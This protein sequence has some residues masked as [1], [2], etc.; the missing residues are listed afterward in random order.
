MNPDAGHWTFKAVDETETALLA[1]VIA[2]TLGPGDLV[3]LTGGLGAG[4][5]AFA[6]A[7]LRAL[8]GDPLLEVPSPT[9]TLMQTYDL[10]VGTAIHADFYRISG[11][12][13]LE[14]I[15]WDESIEGALVLV[16]WP[17]RAPEVI[18][19]ERIDVR[20]DIDPNSDGGGRII[21][22]TGT[23]RFAARI[24]A[25]RHRFELL[26]AS[27]F[28]GARHERIAGDASGRRYERLMRDGK[29]AILMIAP[30]P[31]HGPVIRDD[32]T[33]RMLARLCDPL[34][35]F[36]AV[37]DALR[38]EGLSAPEILAADQ[39][40]GLVVVEDFG[41][42]TIAGPEGPIPQRYHEAVTLL[43]KLHARS[44]PRALPLPGGGVY[45]LPDYGLEP[46]LTEVEL[47]LDWYLPAF[48]GTPLPAS[49]REAFLTLWR[50]ALTPV[51]EG[52][53]TWTLRDFHSP[54]LFW[55]AERDGVRRIGLI[56]FQD[57]LFGPPAYDLAS[58]LQDARQVVSE[59]L[60]I[61]LFA[62][63]VRTRAALDPAFDLE[64][65]GAAYAVLA[66][67]RAT[68]ILGIFVRL[69]RRDGKPGY[70]R[71]LPQ[72][73]TYFARN[74]SHPALRELAVWLMHH[75]PEWTAGEAP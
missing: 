71:L 29:T 7:V 2:D 36:V 60:E 34:D 14:E 45:T 55:L 58:L 51:T 59:D 13:E 61:A 26:V 40:A 69:D 3:T 28:A 43:A 1:G 57:A 56:D 62:H 30:E 52:L 74:L 5:S 20:I 9:F 8:A 33:Y 17:E 44:L 4:K 24:E 42:D 19:A 16:E 12:E 63:Y 32:K 39:A 53:S 23:G 48:S 64:A 46:L 72:I 49:A 73:R 38:A 27:G 15:G 54:N 65:F 35:G 68:K 70:L 6:R 66:A 21:V 22:L 10:P 25:T 18:G 67:Q 11:A 31:V 41:D 50:R 75:C 47:F 37:A